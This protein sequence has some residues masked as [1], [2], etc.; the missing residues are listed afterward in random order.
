MY[1]RYIEVCGDVHERGVQI[2]QQLQDAIMTNYKNQTEF[3]KN[4]ENFDYEKWEEISQRYIPMMQQ[5]TPEVLEELKG[6]AEGA[7]IPLA[8]VVALA[9][10]YEKSFGRDCPSEK[11][12]SFFVTGAATGGKTIAG[13]TNDEN[14]REWRHERDVVIHHK[15]SDGKEILTYTHPG[16]PAYMGINNQGLTVLWTYIDN[17]KT[18][19]GVPTSAII[20]HLLSLPNVEE[21]VAFLE[22]V[23]HDIPNQFGLADRSGKLVCVECF[24]NKV[25]PVWEKESFVHTNHNVYALEEDD[26]TTGKTT[27]DRFATMKKMIAENFGHIDVELAKTF[28]TSHENGTHS[29]CV[30][31]NSERP[32][33]KTLA[34]MVFDVDE[35]IM[36]IAFG[37]PCEVPYQQYRFDRYGI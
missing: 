33:N 22:K 20:R 11:C 13:Q 31:P 28:L 4:T 2:G 17:G 37:N 15:G 19:D 9:T 25:C 6:M 3:Y 12:T 27:R 24:P 16:V 21:A 26:C 1:T 35:G 14:L 8:K 32:F 5:W 30:H 18:R 10:A 36:N 29:I 23:P 7:Q 34:A